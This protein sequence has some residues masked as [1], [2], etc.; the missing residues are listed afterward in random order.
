MKT[1]TENLKLLPSINS[2]KRISQSIAMLD[3]IIYQ[4]WE[5]RYY[6]FNSKWSQNE[7][8]ASMRDGQGSHYFI[9]F[10]I[11]GVMIK[12]YDIDAP[13]NGFTDKEFWK[14]QMNQIPN[15]FD[16]F[17]SEPAFV[18][19]KAT[20]FIWR[21]NSDSHWRTLDLNSLIKE[22]DLKVCDFDGSENLINI[23]DG[24][25]Q[26]YKRWAD[27]YYESDFDL[28]II[29]KIYRHEPLTKEIVETLNSDIDYE[30]LIEDIKEIDYPCDITIIP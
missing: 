11:D 6:S 13:I 8:M 15:Q 3:A 25:P 24:L 1:S 10:F 20:F 29:E 14:D 17:L 22:Q 12:G 28:S 23:L 21:L 9:L 19:D 5:Y 30:V 16:S 18:T 2:L 7:M 26:T 4:E 27:A